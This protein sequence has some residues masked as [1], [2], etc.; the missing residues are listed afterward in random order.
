MVKFW[1]QGTIRGSYYLAT[2]WSK[3]SSSQLVHRNGSKYGCPAT[4]AM[5][6]VVL[7]VETWTERVLI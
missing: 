2:E 7:A 5:A 1:I 3:A 6:L 4:A